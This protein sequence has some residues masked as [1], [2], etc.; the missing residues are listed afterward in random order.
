MLILD[1][2]SKEELIFALIKA[3]KFANISLTEIS[4]KLSELY[5]VRLSPSGVSHSIN[6]GSI[7]FQRALQI[8]TICGVTE[9]A[10]IP[11]KLIPN[12]K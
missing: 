5:G 3:V 1:P 10:I 4:S 6:R 7:R 8:L 11:S 12:E 9:V 2:S